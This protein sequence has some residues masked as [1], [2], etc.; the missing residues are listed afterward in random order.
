LA[1][2]RIL[3]QDLFAVLLDDMGDEADNLVGALGTL[4]HIRM[5]MLE[6]PLRLGTETELRWLMAETDALRRFRAAGLSWPLADNASEEALAEKLYGAAGSKQGHRRH[7]EPDWVAIHRELKRKHVTLSILWD[8]YIEQ[9]PDG[10]RYS[11]FCD[12]YRSWEGKL[13]VTMRQA[14]AGGEKLFVDYAGDRAAVVIDRLTGEIRDALV[15][16]GHRSA[17]CDR[18]HDGQD[19]SRLDRRREHG[20]HR[21]N[22]ALFAPNERQIAP[23]QAMMRV[24]GRVDRTVRQ[25]ERSGRARFPSAW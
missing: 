4:F 17:P 9:H 18:G 24:R 16:R 2:G 3:Y 6:H 14:H 23:K 20:F 7:A 13:S 10:Y 1:R 22:P 21:A 25:C 5:A 19:G 15:L 8:E 12:L 11:R